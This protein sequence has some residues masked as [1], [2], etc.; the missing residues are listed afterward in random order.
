MTEKQQ[1][2]IITKQEASHTK[3]FKVV[4]GNGIILFDGDLIIA[5]S[6]KG[7]LTVKGN[8][9][10]E[11]GASV[12]GSINSSNLYL[13]GIYAGRAVVTNKC[14][15]HSESVFSGQLIS[16]DVDFR[17]GCVFNAIRSSYKKSSYQSDQKEAPVTK[18]EDDKQNKKSLLNELFD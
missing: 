6:F 12:N 2:D 17:D 14:V 5:G 16:N 4:E 15:L 11:A 8:L 10:I 18:K 1:D 7:K 3:S 9:T 13:S